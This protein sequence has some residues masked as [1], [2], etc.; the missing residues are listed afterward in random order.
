MSLSTHVLDTAAGRPAAG[1]AVRLDRYGPDG[2]WT[3]LARGHTGPDGRLS[4]WLPDGQPATGRHRLT[5]GTGGYFAAQGVATLYPEVTITFEVSDAGAHY[6]L[7]VLLSP[8]GYSTY[9]GS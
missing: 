7:P 5:F 9:R 3:E 4:G 8:F 2:G 6:H 1:V